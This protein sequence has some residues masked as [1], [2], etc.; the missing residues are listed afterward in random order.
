MN[1]E[2]MI[3]WA[4]ALESGQ[5]KQHR[6]GWGTRTLDGSDGLGFC[7][8]NVACVVLHGKTWDDLSCDAWT[9]TRHALGLSEQQIEQFPC[10]NDVDVLS[11]TE[12]AARIRK[13]VEEA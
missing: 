6:G 1:K 7:C 2:N 10:M 11:F 8:L 9:G 12:I 5:Y 3:K 13:M 4:E